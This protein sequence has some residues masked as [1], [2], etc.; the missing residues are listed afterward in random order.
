MFVG[1]AFRNENRL[2]VGEGGFD[3]DFENCSESI[4]LREA[5]PTHKQSYPRT[6]TGEYIGG[7][8]ITSRRGYAND[9]SYDRSSVQSQFSKTQC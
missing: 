3:L 8:S 9:R 4:L 6:L 1:V 2:L 5:T 7:G